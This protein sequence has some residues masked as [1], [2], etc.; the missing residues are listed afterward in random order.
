MEVLLQLCAVL[1]A[2]LVCLLSG[3]LSVS[4]IALSV[5]IFCLI[6]ISAVFR[7]MMRQRIQTLISYLMHV[8]DSLELP[9]LTKCREDSLGILHSEIYKL[10]VLLNEQSQEASKGR[11]YLADMLSNISHQLKTPLAGITLLADL[12]KN[13][14]LPAEKR[15]EFAEKINSQADRASWLIRNLLALSQLEAG[16][17]KLKDRKSVV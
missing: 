3:S 10:V 7:L 2:A 8:Q 6:G 14:S 15:A 5:C 17:L 1:A 11:R 9:D 4:C 16:V 12:L 13:P